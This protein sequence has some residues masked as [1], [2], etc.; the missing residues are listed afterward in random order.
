MRRIGEYERQAAA[1]E[2]REHLARP[3]GERLSQSWHMTRAYGKD[4]EPDDQ[5]EIRAMRRFYDRATELGLRI[6]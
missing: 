3:G 2:L 4:V 1:A 5:G 6:R